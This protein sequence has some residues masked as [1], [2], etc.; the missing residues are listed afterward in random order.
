MSLHLAQS[1]LRGPRAA[2]AVGVSSHPPRGCLLLPAA[3]SIATP[4]RR[5]RL[6]ALCTARVPGTQTASGGGPGSDSPQSFACL[7]GD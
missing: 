3:C 4:C 2:A 1:K 6:A 7:S 5:A